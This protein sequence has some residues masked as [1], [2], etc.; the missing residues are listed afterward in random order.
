MQAGRHVNPFQYEGNGGS[1]NTNEDVICTHT[2]QWDKWG[3]EEKRGGEEKGGGKGRER[4][5]V[6][7][8]EGR[9]GGEGGVR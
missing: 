9:G 7:G 1:G 2:R 3:G 4:R 8:G 6:E 5:G